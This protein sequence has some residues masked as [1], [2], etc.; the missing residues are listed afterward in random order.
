MGER[1]PLTGGI[2]ALVALVLVLTGVLTL[3]AWQ[4][5]NQL[6]STTDAATGADGSVPLPAG[7]QGAPLAVAMATWNVLK[8]NNTRRVVAGI[9]TIGRAGADVIGVQE[10][11]R[12]R[13]ATVARQLKHAGWEM[14]SGNSATP[15]FWR[16]DKYT[17]LAQGRQKVFGV[18]RI[19]PGSA[20]G[21]SI[22]P[23][24]IQWVQL[25]DN[26]TG[27]VFIA[28]SNHL[29]PGIE[30]KGHPDPHGHRRVAYAEK[31]LDA[32]TRLAGRLGRSG[33]IPFLIAA[34][35]NVDARKD[36]R[37]RTPGFPYTALQQGGLYSNWR[38]LGYP[39]D[40][41][42]GR[43][44]IDGIFST[45]RTIAPVR[46]QILGRYG[47]DHRAVL[48]HYSNR[49]TGTQTKAVA[50]V[51]GQLSSAP[52][53]ATLI[54][55]STKPRETMTLRG[56]QITNAQIIIDEGR[57]AGIPT[58]GWI[59]ALATALQE[60]GLRNLHRGDRDSQGLFQGRP[61]QGWGTIAQNRDPHLATRAFYGI[62]AHTH[63]PGLTD[64]DGWEAMPV[65]RAAQA[66]QR[67]GFPDAYAKWEPAA[68]SIVD[69]LATGSNDEQSAAPDGCG[70][71][72][73]APIGECPSTGLA[74]EEGLQP[75]ALEVLRCV[76]A[77]N[78]DLTD[79]GG[80]H[81]DAL[82]DHPSGRAVDIMIPEYR[83]P[84]GRAFGWK[85]ANWLKD[86]RLQLGI[87]YL[88]FD[89]KIWSVEHDSD[90]WRPYRPRYT[91]T[92]DDSS[93]HL[94]H[95]HVTTYGHSGTGLTPNSSST[96]TMAAGMWTKP[97]DRGYVL[98]CAWHCY[99]NPVT[100]LPHTGQD[101]KVGIGDPVRST[102]AGTVTVSRDLTGSYGRYIVIQDATDPSITVYYAHLATRAVQVGEKVTAGQVIGRSGSSGNSTGPH[103]HYE[104]RM[105]GTPT[106]PMPV[107]ARHGVHP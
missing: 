65:T 52:T 27:A 26:T 54:V 57:K 28:A 70:T 53:A 25:R 60:S 96:A 6:C 82:P 56:Q 50:M 93:L 95:I 7:S 33:Q 72:P 32:V 102:N 84:E 35:W 41:T 39:T 83:T 16:A 87:D 31:Q 94:N 85:L 2:A 30:T 49:R 61:S 101:F 13:R 8:S 86:H 36:A 58:Y 73:A 92:L 66:V 81:P 11:E 44:L 76:K 104:I 19:E 51:S 23:K 37:T 1:G 67:S 100:H 40:G 89:A 42:H 105:N 59:I 38:V 9:Q 21:S 46:Q 97:L 75:D 4:Q 18:V 74:V 22:G 12:G 106:N 15:V 14:S 99:V 78:P 5:Q 45:S 80:K 10:L 29:V 17:V 20:A 88:I 91:A 107:L 55:P 64:I 47:S 24:F 68:R 48:I 71:Q 90:G 79:F 3:A 69:Q 103:L 98:G 77:A 34:D 43:R 63:N 62:A